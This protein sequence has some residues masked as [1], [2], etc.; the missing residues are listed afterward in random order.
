[1]GGYRPMATILP[2]IHVQN[3]GGDENHHLHGNTSFFH[4]Y[5]FLGQPA[6]IF[7]S[8]FNTDISYRCVHSNLDDSID[9]SYMITMQHHE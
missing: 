5:H 4:L 6:G 7:V 9:S 8:E 1:M 2:D 3:E